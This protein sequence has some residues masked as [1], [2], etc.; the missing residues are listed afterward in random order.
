M[1][2]NGLTPSGE[3]GED[4]RQWY[5]PQILK[6]EK[7]Q[8]D[9]DHGPGNPRKVKFERIAG[10]WNW[11][12]QYEPP[13]DQQITDGIL[14][15][16]SL[17]TKPVGGQNPNLYK[18]VSKIEPLQQGD[19]YVP[20]ADEPQYKED[21]AAPATGK[22]DADYWAQKDIDIKKGMAFN[23]L[24]ILLST[25]QGQAQLHA[26][27]ASKDWLEEWMR[28]YDFASRGLSL[29]NLENEPEPEGEPQETVESL[30]W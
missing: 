27:D 13:S 19:N 22:S 20:P 14:R 4:G 8:P 18:D 12:K 10:Y 6:V 2:I 16:F 25:E 24:T 28:C 21:A 29:P 3:Q 26:M 17:T 5:K 1:S 23:N 15:W 11:P 7:H 30:K 9:S